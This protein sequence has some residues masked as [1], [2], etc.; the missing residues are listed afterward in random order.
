MN[1]LIFTKYTAQYDIVMV[2]T[3]AFGIIE[4]ENSAKQAFY[5]DEEQWVVV[6]KILIN[7]NLLK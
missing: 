7:I 4:V 1:I 3:E 5:G 6:T 2:H